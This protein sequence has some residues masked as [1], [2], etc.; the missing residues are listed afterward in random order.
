M[1]VGAMLSMQNLGQLSNREMTQ[2]LQEGKNNALFSRIFSNARESDGSEEQIDTEMMQLLDLLH[3]LQ[4]EETGPPEEKE[5]PAVDKTGMLM[6]AGSTEKELLEAMQS[7]IQGISKEVPQLKEAVSILIDEDGEGV[8]VPLMEM[9]SLLSVDSLKKL[10]QSS[11]QLFIKVSKIVEH[12]LRQPDYSSQQAE[13][14]QNSLKNLSQKLE[15]F[16]NSPNN[17]SSK[18]NGILQQA[19][20]TNNL[21][22]SGD[23]VSKN[24][25]QHSYLVNKDQGAFY[26]LPGKFLSLNS[27]STD[28]AGETFLEAEKAAKGNGVSLTSLIGQH[29]TAKVEQFSLFINKSQGGTTYE[30][31]VKEFANILARSQMVQTPNMSKLLIK[32]YPEQLGSLRIE[33]LQQN[34]VMTAR[35]LASTKAAK[36][37]LDSQLTGLRQALS[38]QNLQVEKIEVAQ[39]LTESTRQERQS[40]QQQNGQQP[41]EQAAQQQNENE[42][43]ETTFKELLMNSE[44]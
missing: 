13:S 4:V 3:I 41:R 44:E 43:S 38:N 25:V 33:I 36:E 8:M 34:G 17:K 29:Q 23:S 35:I 24:G 32:L 11:L 15:H 5:L 26:N 22:S 28:S 42:N 12:G 21:G 7:L 2:G 19:F 14:L 37:I 31:F 16:F 9:L 40:P 10:D 6:E 20:E 1:N 30:Q 27:S 39:T 18:W